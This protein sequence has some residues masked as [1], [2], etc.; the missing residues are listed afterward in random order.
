MQFGPLPGMV[1]ATPVL[2]AES[3][4]LF[5]HREV[6]EPWLENDEVTSAL[7]FGIKF[8]LLGLSNSDNAFARGDIDVTDHLDFNL[9]IDKIF[10]MTKNG[11]VHMA[12][13]YSDLG[14][15]ALSHFTMADAGNY[16]D[17]SVQLHTVVNKFGTPRTLMAG[18]INFVY[19]KV[20]GKDPM[21]PV[22]IDGVANLQFGTV[23]VNCVIESVDVRPIGYTLRAYRANANRRP[24]SSGKCPYMS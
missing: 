21:V 16:Q 18:L 9:S 15:V 3:A 5:A 19:R 4:H 6:V 7:K 23:L 17:M 8:D 22:R 24:V 2:R 12:S 14:V 20:L 11:T 10:Y 1:L 13:M